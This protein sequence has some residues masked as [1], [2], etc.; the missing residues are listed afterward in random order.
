MNIQFVVMTTEVYNAYQSPHSFLISTTQSYS[1]SSVIFRAHVQCGHV[2]F[3]F[4]STL[5]FNPVL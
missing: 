3:L 1:C 4:A 5:V 2:F